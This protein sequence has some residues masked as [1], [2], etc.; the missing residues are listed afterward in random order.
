MRVHI[1][2]NLHVVLDA[3]LPAIA[4]RDAEQSDQGEGREDR[5]AL[6]RCMHVF[7]PM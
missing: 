2:F 7:H 3:L 1:E 5:K 6:E 4:L